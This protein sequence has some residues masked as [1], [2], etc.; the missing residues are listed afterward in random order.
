MGN[1]RS[2]ISGVQPGII[3][4]LMGQASGPSV[5]ANAIKQRDTSLIRDRAGNTIQTRS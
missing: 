3:G 2:I 1:I 4:G 5:P